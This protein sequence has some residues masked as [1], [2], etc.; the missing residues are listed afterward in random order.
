MK[1]KRKKIAFFDIDGTLTSEKDGAIPMSAANAIRAAR[2]NG[3]LMFLNT[4][5]CFQ[6]IEE[7][8]RAVGFDGYVCGCGTDIY[9]GETRLLHIVQSHD[10]TMA[11]LRAA[12][13]ADIDILFESSGAVAFDLSR[14]IKHPAAIAQYEAFR[15]RGYDMPRDLE[16]SEFVCDKFVV[17][18]EN[19]SQLSLFR[20][21]SDALFSCI[22]RGGTFREF[23]P[24][25]Y[26]KATGLLTVLAHCK[27]PLENAYAFGDSSND[28]PMLSCVKNSVAMGNASPES[29]KERVSFVTKRASE[30]GIAFALK[31][32]GFI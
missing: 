21:T 28:V 14:A 15:R 18:Y 23:V 16:A 24:I 5:R 7:R 32:F 17:W 10:V 4:G 22:D 3:N 1:N 9:C 26:S 20:E 6:N 11:L 27:I 12:R 19:E 30:D 31:R 2:A 8:F 13:E 25:G 29:L